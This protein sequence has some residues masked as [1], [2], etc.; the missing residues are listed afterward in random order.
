MKRNGFYVKESV[1]EL[2]IQFIHQ[3]TTAV[4]SSAGIK[5]QFS[6]GIVHSSLRNKLGA[7]KA[8]KLV[9]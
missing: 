5:I 1:T 9:F 8:S 2:E 3:L 4:A 7:N 6:F